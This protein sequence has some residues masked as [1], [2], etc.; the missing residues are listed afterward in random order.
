M[1]VTYQSPGVYVEEIQRGTRP[2]EAV[3]TSTAAMVRVGNAVGRGDPKGISH[4]GWAGV[5]LSV[6]PL[7]LAPVVIVILALL[8]PS[9][10]NVF[11]DVLLTVTAQAP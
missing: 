8:G 3:G 2:I 10:G 6:L 5:A 4:A 7:C 9:I 1:A 11:S